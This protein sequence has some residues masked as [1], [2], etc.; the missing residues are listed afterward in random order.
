MTAIHR[1]MNSPNP[2]NN[3]CSRC[4][5]HWQSYPSFLFF[6]PDA[7]AKML[8]MAEFASSRFFLL[9]SDVSDYM[10]SSAPV[11]KVDASG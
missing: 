11:S 2:A 7:A 3:W 4:R 10:K 9:S 6:S 1:K 5:S 8:E